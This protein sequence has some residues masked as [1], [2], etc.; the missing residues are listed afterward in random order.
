MAPTS[1]SSEKMFHAYAQAGGYFINTPDNYQL[2]ADA[3]R[4]CSRRQ[5]ALP[6]W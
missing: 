6:D 5:F 2:Q 4:R 3:R 1:K